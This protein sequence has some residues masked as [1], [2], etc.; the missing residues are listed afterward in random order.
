MLVTCCWGGGGREARGEYGFL[1]FG[2]P[3][4]RMPRTRLIALIM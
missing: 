2:G 1:H 3:M 4:R